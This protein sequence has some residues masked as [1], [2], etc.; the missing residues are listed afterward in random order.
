MNAFC[1][2]E[3]WQMWT[4]SCTHTVAQ[5]AL[6]RGSCT[7]WICMDQKIAWVNVGC[8]LSSCQ[9]TMSTDSTSSGRF[10]VKSAFS[11]CVCICVCEHIYIQHLKCVCLWEREG[12]TH[13]TEVEEIL[14]FVLGAQVSSLIEQSLGDKDMVAHLVSLSVCVCVWWSKRGGDL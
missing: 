2:T 9:M 8:C 10:K 6:V 4:T 14:E 5:P 1:T 12:A 3:T 7:A 13:L 11:L